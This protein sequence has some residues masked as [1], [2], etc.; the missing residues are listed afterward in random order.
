VTAALAIETLC[1]DSQEQGRS[2]V[3]VVL[4][5]QPLARLNRM[6]VPGIPGVSLL[7]SRQAALQHALLRPA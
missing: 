3:I 4:G 2:V 6:G 5:D 7:P 1:L